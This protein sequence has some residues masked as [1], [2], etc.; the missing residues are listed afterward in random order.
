M[1]AGCC[2]LDDL[3][4]A[5]FSGLVVDIAGDLCGTDCGDHLWDDRRMA[6]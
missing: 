1:D 4:R 6:E 2:C 5:N 3:F